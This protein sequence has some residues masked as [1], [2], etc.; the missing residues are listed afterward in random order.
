[1]RSSNRVERM[2]SAPKS[3][4]CCAATLLLV[5][6]PLR[7]A[8]EAVRAG[9]IPRPLIAT[10]FHP[11]Q[12]ILL[13][14]SAPAQR[15]V[16][17]RTLDR[18]QASG[19]NAIFPYFTGSAGQ[20]YYCSQL[21]AE[22]VYGEID[23]LGTLVTEAH[24]RG[25]QVYA[26][27]CVTVCGHE[28]PR[29]VLLQH[30]EWALR[31]P[32]GTPL[33][34]IS[35]A[36]PEARQWL[37]SV[38]REIV[39]MYQVD[40]VI[41][42]YI[43]YHNRPLLL[44]A[45]SESRFRATVPPGSSADEERALLQQF[46]ED[47]LTELVRLYREAIQ[48]AAPNVRLGIYSWGPHVAANH[49]IAQCWPRWVAAGYLDLVNISGYYHREKYGDDYLQRFADKMHGAVELNRATGRPVPLSFALGVDT[50]HGSIRT[51]AEV[52]PYL[53]SAAEN[54]IEGVVAFTWHALLPLL[55]ELDRT[56]DLR[57]LPRQIPTGRGESGDE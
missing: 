14:D 38:A 1:M 15:A 47:Q 51:A 3:R 34:Y 48:A 5:L 16:I 2:T 9:E 20:A 40:G 27:L 56:G 35:P 25:L 13:T 7:R 37:A 57:N 45:E 44:D 43:R 24:R 41:L 23:P 53:Q 18:M 12:S 33:G 36:H 11:T 17:E 30:G 28:S 22:A 42:D 29:G 21:H 55:D 54:Q 4:L 39:Q 10:Y 19:F 31:H 8:D 6:L 49:Q 46:K 50:S 26:V 32:D 52:G